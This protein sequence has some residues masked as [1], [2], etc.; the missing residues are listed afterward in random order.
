M[1]RS[2]YNRGFTLIETVLY[3]A[4]FGIV[5]GGA[6]VGAYSI[7]ES[8]AHNQTKA[9][10]IEEGSY[11]TGKIDWLLSNAADVTVTPTTLL[12][13]K[14]DGS[15]ATIALSGG[16]FTL[17]GATLPLNNS[18]ITVE[19]LSG[20]PV[21]VHTLASGS[22]VNPESVRATFRLST[23]TLSGFVF[24]QDFSTAKYLRK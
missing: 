5:I 18:N 1:T 15:A 24:S 19:A 13:T 20:T 14:F 16:N 7:F 10:V 4:L 21:F 2:P 23:H 11:L 6:I 8:A 12:V 22:G 3:L 9:M 17:T